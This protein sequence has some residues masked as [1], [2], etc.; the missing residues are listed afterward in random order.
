MYAV[1]EEGRQLP[2]DKIRAG[3][4]AAAAVGYPQ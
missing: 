4:L 2:Q 3:F 1:G